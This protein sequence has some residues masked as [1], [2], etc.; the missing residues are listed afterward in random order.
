[1]R[2]LPPRQT[3]AEQVYQAIVDAV[4]DGSFAPGAHLVQEELAARLGVSRQPVQ[5]AMAMLKADGI[6]EESGARGLYVAPVDLATMRHR[7]A[8]RSALD[9]LAASGAARAVL[10]GNRDIAEQ[11]R[12]LVATGRSAVA[13][14][15]VRALVAADITFHQFIYEASGNPLIAPTAEIHWHFLRR[16]MSDVVRHAQPPG[17]IWDQHEGIV[18]AIASGDA[19]AAGRLAEAHVERAAERLTAARQ[20][21]EPAG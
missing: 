21:M 3:A 19:D 14:G 9:A 15:E 13:T 1:M 2:K 7:Y 10:A 11:A 20:R 8:I 16:V 6:V 4:S 17:E 5:Q 18:E 12:R